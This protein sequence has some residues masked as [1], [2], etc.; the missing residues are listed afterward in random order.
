MN[1]FRNR[2]FLTKKLWG[3]K[4]ETSDESSKQV[5]T[6]RPSVRPARSLCSD[7]ARAKARSLYSDRASVSLGRY[8]ATEP[9]PS[10]VAT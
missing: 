10:S 4:N 3:R 2:F 7:R 9:E 1:T 6:Q 5:V 8:V